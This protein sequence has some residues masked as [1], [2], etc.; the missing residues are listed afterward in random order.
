MVYAVLQ[1]EI[2]WLPGHERAEKQDFSE[3]KEGHDETPDIFNHG[4][5]GKEY[6]LSEVED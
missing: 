4:A 5:K 1:V 6:N 2:A 3:E